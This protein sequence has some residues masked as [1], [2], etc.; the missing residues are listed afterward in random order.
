[1]RKLFILCAYD[2]PTATAIRDARR[3]TI[4]EIL[5]AGP[6]SRQSDF[7]VL[8]RER[9]IEATQSSISRDLNEL[10][11]A[12]LGEGYAQLQ[13]NHEDAED[14]GMVQQGAG[15]ERKHTLH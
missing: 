5:A 14:I 3:R 2:M 12:K 13:T 11:V 1:M 8:L 9:G 15:A 4:L 10:G 6:V 7:V